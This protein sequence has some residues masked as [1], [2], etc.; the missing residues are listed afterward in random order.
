MDNS[1]FLLCKPTCMNVRLWNRSFD[2][3]HIMW[4]SNQRR[5]EGVPSVGQKFEKCIHS[6]QIMYTI[7]KR[8]CM[9]SREE[10][11]HSASL[12]QREEDPEFK[13]RPSL[14]IHLKCVLFIRMSK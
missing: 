10:L 6:T 9:F 1:M 11:F 12:A 13:P 8:V 14:E 3:L 2:L 5:M 7:T 4:P